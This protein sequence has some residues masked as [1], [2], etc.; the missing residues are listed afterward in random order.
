MR[1]TTSAG[2][3]AEVVADDGER[4]LDL[5]VVLVALAACQMRRGTPPVEA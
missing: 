4:H 3:G 5:A 1:R 2:P